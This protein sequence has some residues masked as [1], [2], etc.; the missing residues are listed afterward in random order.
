V[1]ARS[2]V[3]RPILIR[4]ELHISGTEGEPARAGRTIGQRD[5]HWAPPVG[6]SAK[7][8]LIRLRLWQ[9]EPLGLSQP[10]I[11]LRSRAFA[12][13]ILKAYRQSSEFVVPFMSKFEIELL[14]KNG[15][16]VIGV[17]KDAE[18][19]LNVMDEAMRQYPTGHIRIRCGATVFAE[20]MPPRAV[21]R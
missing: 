9:C 19:A 16:S 6:R 2:G 21:P 4:K 1:P 8:L 5:D 18:S 17:A 11:R 14:S 3:R 7:A 12:G 10:N 13:P 20:R 15:T